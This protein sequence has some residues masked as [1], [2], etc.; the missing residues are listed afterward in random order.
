MLHDRH[1]EWIEARGI[2]PILAEKLGLTTTR[3]ASGF[4]LTVPYSER[5]EVINHKYRMTSEKRHR[6]DSGA[7]LAL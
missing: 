6:M 2:D 1:R 7:P 4:W 3:D 5:G